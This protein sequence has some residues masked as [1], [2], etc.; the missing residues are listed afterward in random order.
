VVNGEDDHEMYTSRETIPHLTRYF[1]SSG[2][3]DLNSR[4]LD[5]QIGGHRYAA[6][7]ERAGPIRAARKRLGVP[8]RAV[9]WA[10]VGPK[11]C[12]LA[13]VVP[14]PAGDH[15]GYS[16]QANL[17]GERNPQCRRGSYRTN[18]SITCSRSCDIP[19]LAG[20]RPD[21]PRW[22]A[23]RLHSAKERWLRVGTASSNRSDLMSSMGSPSVEGASNHRMS[24]ARSTTSKGTTTVLTSL[25]VTLIGCLVVA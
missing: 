25:W 6:L 20:V 2:W 8:P 19:R 10:Q 13:G 5:P 9:R 23:R 4:P 3:R 7:T 24:S 17:P 15:E 18:L 16:A 12:A 1:A 14:R 11:R 21:L 22:Q